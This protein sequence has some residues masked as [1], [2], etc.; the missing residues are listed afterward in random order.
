MPYEYP[1]DSFISVK[2]TYETIFN[3]SSYQGFERKF[4][5]DIITKSAN[6][7]EFDMS[8]KDSSKSGW[9]IFTLKSSFY[10]DNPSAS[11]KLITLEK[12]YRFYVDFCYIDSFKDVSAAQTAFGNKTLIQHMLS[13]GKVEFR[14]P[15]KDIIKFEPSTCSEHLE[16]VVFMDLEYVVPG[17]AQITGGFINDELVEYIPETVKE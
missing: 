17:A 3:E 10:V 16:K 15:F 14:S 12:D 6:Y 1:G 8:E 7:I 11:F 4:G 5:E 2:D 13:Y 9:Y